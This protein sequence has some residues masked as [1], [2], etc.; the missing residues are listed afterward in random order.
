MTV[1]LDYELVYQDLRTDSLFAHVHLGS[2]HPAERILFFLC[3][4]GSKT[5]ATN[6]EAR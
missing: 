3:G 5:L 2:I 1:P 4:E 6:G